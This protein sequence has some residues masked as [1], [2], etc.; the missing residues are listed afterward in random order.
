VSKHRS[1]YYCENCGLEL[2]SKGR[3]CPDCANEVRN[4]KMIPKV[5]KGKPMDDYEKMGKSSGKFGKLK[6][7][8]KR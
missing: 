1:T 5:K 8:E 4:R 7:L 2:Y 3:L 6:K